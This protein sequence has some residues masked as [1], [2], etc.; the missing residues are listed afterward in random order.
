MANNVNFLNNT[1][2][3]RGGAIYSEGAVT[4]T[5]SVID[6]NDITYRAK[7]EDNGGAAIY[8]LGGTLTI[9]NTD[10]TNNLK[11]IVIR[12]GNDGHLINAVIYTTG[13]TTITDS[14]IANN[15]GS[16]GAGVYVTNGTTLTVSNTLF[17]GNNAT[18][19][20]CI[21]DEGAVISVDNCTFNDNRAVGIGSAGTSNTQAAAILVMGDDSSATIA[22]SKFNRNSA[23]VG[24]AVSFAGVANDS[25]IDNCTFTNNT[26][27]VDGGA[28]YFWTDGAGVTITDSEFVNNSAPYGGAIENEGIGDLTVAPVDVQH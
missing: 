15:T 23:K 13:D 22:N 3:Y 8:N 10:I 5:D 17:E 21:Y 19:G 1:A 6:S 7:N 14:Y 9:E 16:W 4:V 24:G 18:F 20:S 26:A 12:D 2:V 25:I 28:L 27:G 11:D